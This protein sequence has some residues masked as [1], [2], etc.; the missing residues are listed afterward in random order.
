MKKLFIL[1]AFPF[2][3]NSQT[4][5]EGKVVKDSTQAKITIV[6]RSKEEAKQLIESLRDRI[7]SGESFSE[8]AMQY[9]D[10]PGSAKKGGML[11]P[12]KRGQMVPEFEEVVYSLKPGEISD[13]FETKYGFHFVQLMNRDGETRVARHILVAVK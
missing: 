10:D 6:G 4:A 8:L 13:V 11:P 12:L 9:S 5:V 7:N 2:I 1:I 3:L